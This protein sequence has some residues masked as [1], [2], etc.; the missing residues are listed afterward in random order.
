MHIGVQYFFLTCLLV[1]ILNLFQSVG[2]YSIFFHCIV[3]I[4]Y[5]V[6]SDLFST[7]YISVFSSFIFNK[8]S[9]PQTQ[10]IQHKDI[11]IVHSIKCNFILLTVFTKSLSG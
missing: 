9:N 7:I 11:F 6:H 2:I 8:M 10:V 1:E 3:H 5:P 4:K